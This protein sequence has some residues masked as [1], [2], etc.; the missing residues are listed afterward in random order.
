MCKQ[1][2]KVAAGPAGKPRND[3]GGSGSGD[4]ARLS[5]RERSL[6]LLIEQKQAYQQFFADKRD[7]KSDDKDKK[8]LAANTMMEAATRMAGSGKKKR[9]RSKKSK[10][11]K[12]KGTSDDSEASSDTDGL[13]VPRSVLSARAQQM[14]PVYLVSLYTIVDLNMR[15]EARM[16]RDSVTVGS[17]CD[18]T[19]MITRRG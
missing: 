14:E 15:S 4:I 6:Q 7:L 8:D 3:I 13:Q 16:A 17:R 10:S 18:C 19:Q 5:E 2:Q 11:A 1:L 12:K 9:K